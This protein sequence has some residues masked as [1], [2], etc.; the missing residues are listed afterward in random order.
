MQWKGHEYEWRE[1]A[2]VLQYSSTAINTDTNG[3]KVIW[4]SSA[5][6]LLSTQI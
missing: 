5:V 4:Y 2:V 3:E 6:Q 1:G